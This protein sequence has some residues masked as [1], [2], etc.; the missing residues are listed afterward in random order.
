M[1]RLGFG[2]FGY[3]L[4]FFEVSEHLQKAVV[5][6]ACHLPA[7]RFYRLQAFQI[8][9]DILPVQPVVVVLRL[10]QHNLLKGFFVQKLLQRGDVERQLLVGA[11]ENCLQG[12]LDFR[13]HHGGHIQLG[14]H[15]GDVFGVLQQ[16]RRQLASRTGGT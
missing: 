4:G 10:R 3:T 1:S 14:A 15:I 5:R 9:I 12:L 13:Q 16:R 2:C 8:H 11:A 7:E 6:R